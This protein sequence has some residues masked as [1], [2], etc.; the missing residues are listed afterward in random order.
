MGFSRHEYGVSCHYLFQGIFLT[1]GLNLR[2]LHWQADSL[3]LSHQ[4]NPC[5]ILAASIFQTKKANRLQALQM[6]SAIVNFSSCEISWP[7][8]FGR[9]CPLAPKVHSPLRFLKDS[10]Y[11]AC[12]RHLAARMETHWGRLWLPLRR[13]VG[14]I[15]TM[16]H[17]PERNHLIPPL[18]P[19]LSAGGWGGHQRV[20]RGDDT[21][22][23]A[24]NLGPPPFGA[25]ELG[26]QNSILTSTNPCL[27][28]SLSFIV[29]CS[30]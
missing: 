4:L 14:V 8:A 26:R 13:A 2:L 3:R 17:H 10:V 24:L 6:T 15:R 25:H 12:F 29:R 9:N 22:V 19:P 30:W 7:K 27:T 16:C 11:W 20:C 18:Y 5:K 28:S 21:Q 23:E 1:K